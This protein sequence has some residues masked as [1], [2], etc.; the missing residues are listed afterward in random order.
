MILTFIV[1]D[2]KIVMN[3]INLLLMNQRHDFLMIFEETRMRFSMKLKINI[4]SNLQSFLT[5]YALRLMFKEFKRLSSQ[6]TIL[7]ACIN[8][9]ITSLRLPSSHRIQA[10]MF[11]EG[12]LLIEDIHSHSRFERSSS[13][14]LVLIANNPDDSTNS[15][16][17]VQ[18]LEVVRTRGRLADAENRR[19][20]VFDDFTYREPSQYKRAETVIQ[21]K[22]AR[23]LNSKMKRVL[24]RADSASSRDRSRD[25]S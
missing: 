11:N 4:F 3:N 1:N 18:E 20:R 6:S 15:L 2:L 24:R 13:I 5:S 16:L 7:L 22:E 21:L 12:A 10:R 17:H 8:S 25:R 19:Q 14:D 9:F 23:N